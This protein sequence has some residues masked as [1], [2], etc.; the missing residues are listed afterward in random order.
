MQSV[1]AAQWWR[2]NRT[3]AHIVPPGTG[4]GPEGFS[5]ADMILH[6]MPLG[7]VLDFGCGTGRLA[8]Y[9]APSMYIGVDINR[10]AIAHCVN[11]YPNRRFE[12]ADEMLPRAD[13]AFAYTVLLHVPDEEL[14]GTLLRLAAAVSRV[15][16]VE[17]LGRKWRRDGE[18]ATFNRTQYDYE[19]AFRE[20]GMQL[21]AAREY[22]YKRYGGVSITALD[23]RRTS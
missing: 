4:S 23:F 2:D 9:F 15:L 21:T 7:V 14:S 5:I 3:L 8:Q 11:A 18:P 16:V 22:P 17:I 12:I 6:F 13:C 10:V 20:V 19:I 1:S